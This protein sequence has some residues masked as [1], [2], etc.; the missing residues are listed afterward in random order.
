MITK[1]VQSNKKFTVFVLLFAII[2]SNQ[3]ML[4]RT[5]RQFSFLCTALPGYVEYKLSNEKEYEKL[6]KKYSQKCSRKVK[7]LQGIYYKLAQ[8][9]SN[10]PR[11]CPY[12]YREEMKQFLDNVPAK[13]YEKMIDS[14]PDVDKKLVQ[15]NAIVDSE[16]LA[17]GSIGQVH[18][19]TI[20]DKKYVLKI[21]HKDIEKKT[22][23]DLYIVTTWTKHFFKSLSSLVQDFAD[24]TMTEFDFK[25]EF[26]NQM[27]LYD[28]FSKHTVGISIPRP[29]YKYTSKNSLCMEYINGHKLTEKIQTEREKI[30]SYIQKIFISIIIQIKY[31][32]CFSTDP[33]LGNFLV[34]SDDNLVAIDFGQFC[35]I[36]EKMY[37]FLNSLWKIIHKSTDDKEV[38][39]LMKQFGFHSKNDSPLF[40]SRYA[41]LLLDTNNGRSDEIEK[42]SNE[43][44]SIDEFIQLPPNT[45]LV[46]K[47][48]TTLTGMCITFDLK[49]RFSELYMKY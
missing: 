14:I 49:F 9:F 24:V 16:P 35:K 15:D 18:M 8:V 21:L 11:L 34:T 7:K 37:A 36:D 10:N 17:S 3:K 30:A 48:M 29:V 19:V 47:A 42:D 20:K 44:F 23:S 46:V 5:Q 32:K 40:F 33:H 43:L 28:L 31:G 38:Q 27:F 26:E 1:N 41:R 6:H 4:Y 22:L 13:K 2:F 25:K 45:G 12:E 39:E